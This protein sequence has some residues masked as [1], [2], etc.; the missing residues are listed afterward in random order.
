MSE[1]HLVLTKK[2][3]DDQVEELLS[4]EC[5]ETR[6]KIEDI[7]RKL[8]RYWFKEFMH[9]K[10]ADRCEQLVNERQAK[11]IHEKL[12]EMKNEKQLCEMMLESL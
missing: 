6:Q 1:A 5:K 9:E 11:I 2:E 7:E 12:I 4:L 8:D 3:G 10:L